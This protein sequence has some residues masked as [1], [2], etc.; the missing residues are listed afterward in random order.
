MTMRTEH[1]EYL[2]GYLFRSAFVILGM[3]FMIIGDVDDPKS[4]L[5]IC[6]GFIALC[7]TELILSQRISY[8]QERI[9]DLERKTI[10][11]F[12]EDD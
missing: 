1:K 11:T 6:G 4:T 8:L 10:D 12:R 5:F 9:K 2:K 7:G 3:I